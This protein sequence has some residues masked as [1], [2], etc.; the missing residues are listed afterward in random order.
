MF[1]TAIDKIAN[2]NPKNASDITVLLSRFPAFLLMNP[3][4]YSTHITKVTISFGSKYEKSFIAL[5]S[6]ITPMSIVKVRK[7]N[8]KI[9][10]LYARLSSK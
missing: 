7:M 2:T 5:G 8:P 1:T 9:M 6:Q 3:I 4:E 10:A